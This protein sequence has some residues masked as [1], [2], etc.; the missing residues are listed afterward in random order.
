VLAAARDDR[1][2]EQP[3][4]ELVRAVLRSTTE[5]LCSRQAATPGGRK[6]K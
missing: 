2:G 4:D 6:P 1:S 5:Q 3:L